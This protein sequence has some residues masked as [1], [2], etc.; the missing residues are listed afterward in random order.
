MLDDLF[1]LFIIDEEQVPDIVTVFVVNPEIS[2]TQTIMEIPF[3]PD[4]SI[5]VI[6]RVPAV[7]DSVLVVLFDHDRTSMV[8]VLPPDAVFQVVDINVF[9]DQDR[10]LVELFPFSILD[11]GCPWVR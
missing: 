4:L 2:L 6:R 10:A 11:Q 8:V 7:L 9:C 1:N 3:A 5:R